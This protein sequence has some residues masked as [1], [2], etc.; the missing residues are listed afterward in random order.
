[1]II[2]NF[3]T[4]IYTGTNDRWI[5]DIINKNSQML[6]EKKVDTYG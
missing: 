4:K 2:Y 3:G 1:M 5:Y 6:K